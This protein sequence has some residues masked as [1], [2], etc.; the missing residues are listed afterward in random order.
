[1]A[2]IANAIEPDDLTR[3]VEPRDLVS[4]VFQRQMGFERTETN[5][6]N[7]F[8]RLPQGIERL[9]LLN[10]DALADQI[11][12]LAHVVRVHSHRQAD[13]PEYT[14]GATRG[15]VGK[16]DSSEHGRGD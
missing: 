8:E 3:Q 5:A 1:M 16:C 2:H 13:L 15:V 9:P 11:V 4:T 7:R 10:A 12:H 6:V 14:G